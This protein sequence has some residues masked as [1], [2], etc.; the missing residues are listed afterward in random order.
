MCVMSM[1]IQD[2]IDKWYDYLPPPGWPSDIAPIT[3][4]K[5]PSQEEITDFWRLYEKAKEYD[6]QNGEP[7]C[8]DTKKKALLSQLAKQLGIEIKFPDEDDK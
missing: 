1:I 2:R 3:F 4:P 5:I 7:E 8:E 6:R